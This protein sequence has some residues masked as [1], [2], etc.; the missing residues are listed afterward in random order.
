MSAADAPAESPGL[1]SVRRA[2][3]RGR[4]ACLLVLLVFSLVLGLPG[5]AD[6]ATRYGSVSNSDEMQ[7][8]S[9]WRPQSDWTCKVRAY[10][11]ID[12]TNAGI[13]HQGACQRGMLSVE[14]S[15]GTTTM[16]VNFNGVGCGAATTVTMKAG[17]PTGF[18]SGTAQAGANYSKRTTLVGAGCEPS[19]VCVGDVK[20]VR[21]NFFDRSIEGTVCANIDLGPKPGQS[22]KSCAYGTVTK[23]VVKVNGPYKQ[24]IA[25][26]ANGYAHSAEFRAS[27][28]TTTGDP[29]WQSSVPNSAR[30]MAYVVVAPKTAATGNNSYFT[31][32]SM[33][34]TTVFPTTIPYAG[35]GYHATDTPLGSTKTFSDTFATSGTAQASQSFIASN[36]EVIGYGIAAVRDGNYWTVPTT[37]TGSTSKGRVGYHDPTACAWYWGK[38]LTGVEGVEWDEPGGAAEVTDV[39]TPDPV[40]PDGNE[41]DPDGTEPVIQPDDPSL[42]EPLLALI[43]GLLDLLQALIDLVQGIFGVLGEMLAAILGLAAAIGQAFMDAI[44]GLVGLFRDM[45][46]AIFVPSDG[47]MDSKT[48]ELRDDWDNTSPGRWADAIGMM[49]PTQTTTSSCAG[50]PLQVELPGGLDI[51]ERLGEACS[52]ASASA[53]SM[54]RL[55]LSAIMIVGGLFASARAIGAGLGWTVTTNPAAGA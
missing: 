38:K 46:S 44:S 22:G 36:G 25:G 45:L 47:F 30:W 8:D 35:N 10:W 2:S 40:D 27:A 5:V 48:S 4:S 13:A 17:T 34:G 31:G 14:P 52:G 21:D 37:A 33:N 43:S 19:E 11:A 50:L 23:P 51:D 9:D 24:V 55:A 28:K 1:V 6:A 53:A 39:G 20:Q 18:F 15:Q 42:L 3:G 16:S 12:G 49:N 41:T 29:Y 26:N 7:L 54:V 32:G